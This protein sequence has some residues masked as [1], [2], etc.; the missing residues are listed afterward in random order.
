MACFIPE[1]GIQVFSESGYP[2]HFTRYWMPRLLGV[3][4]ELRMVLTSVF[5]FAFNDLSGWLSVVRSVFWCF[6]IWG[7]EGVVKYG[8]NSPLFR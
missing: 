6:I 5:V 8:M 7:K 1:A 4:L 2:F 3:G